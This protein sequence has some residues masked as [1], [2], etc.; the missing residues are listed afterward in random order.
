MQVIVP[1]LSTTL[2]KKINEITPDVNLA[3]TDEGMQVL[4]SILRKIAKDN[5]N[6]SLQEIRLSTFKRLAVLD[7]DVRA[8]ANKY[9]LVFGKT[10]NDELK[11]V[12]PSIDLKSYN[13]KRLIELLETPSYKKKKEDKLINLLTA[14]TAKERS[15]SEQFKA[16]EG[17]IREPCTHLTEEECK[18]DSGT[19]TACNKLHFK[20]IIRPHTDES[21]GNCSYLHTCQRTSCRYVH[22][23]LDEEKY[24]LDVPLST[25]M[26]SKSAKI[27]SQWIHCDARKID[28]SILGK[29]NV[30]M[31]DPPWTI[32]QTVSLIAHTHTL[33]H[34][35][36]TT[37]TIHTRTQKKEKKKKKISNLHC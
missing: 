10:S 8:L 18:K 20:K 12:N 14:T 21:L 19:K 16:G 27:P 4:G 32:R 26:L 31:A 33:Y 13:R 15:Y 11:N 25:A 7:V 34:A 36:T 5:S 30:V 28:F 29:F 1:T 3:E 6:F 22:Y 24:S 35:T 23:R 9:E 37:T 17:Y 2:L